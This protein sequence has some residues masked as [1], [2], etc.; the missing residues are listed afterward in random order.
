LQ[1]SKSAKD[2]GV[3]FGSG[4]PQGDE[5]DSGSESPK[6]VTGDRDYDDNTGGGR[7]R[8]WANLNWLCRKNF[9]LEDSG[10]TRQEQ[11]RVVYYNMLN[12]K[13]ETATKGDYI[14]DS[15]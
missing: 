8:G 9:S 6:K 10:S 13:K 1:R 14:E 3:V 4:Q 11:C 15:T 12:K 5:D 7:K 2:E